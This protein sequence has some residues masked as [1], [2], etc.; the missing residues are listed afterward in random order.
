MS[1]PDFMGRR[2]STE[3][4]SIGFLV[5][6]VFETTPPPS[7]AGWVA[8]GGLSGWVAGTGRHLVSIN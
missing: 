3:H 6:R 5:V 1:L 2:S 8:G 4:E 7:L